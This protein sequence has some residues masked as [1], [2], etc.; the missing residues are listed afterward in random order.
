MFG[1]DPRGDAVEAFR[2]ETG[3][4]EL[5]RLGWRF[6]STCGVAERFQ[7]REQDGEWQDEFAEVGEAL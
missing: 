3:D 2:C 1:L 5:G 4:A 7:T 6:A